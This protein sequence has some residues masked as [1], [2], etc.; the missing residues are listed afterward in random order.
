MRIVDPQI[1][2]AFCKKRVRAGENAGP[3]MGRC[4]GSHS[5]VRRAVN[6]DHLIRHIDLLN[7]QCPQAVFQ[8]AGVSAAG[9]NHG[10]LGGWVHRCIGL[11]QPG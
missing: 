3:I 4:R 9:H 10:D 11:H 2:R 5:R 1:T 7:L 6:D 8:L